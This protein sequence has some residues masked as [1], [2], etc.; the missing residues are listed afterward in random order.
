MA[1][2]QKGEVVIVAKYSKQRIQVDAR[3][4]E[5]IKQV[6]ERFERDLR[7]PVNSLRILHQGAPVEGR[8]L[9]KVD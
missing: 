2:K 7:V 9:V 5:T 1:A 4:N 6:T 3:S 8:T